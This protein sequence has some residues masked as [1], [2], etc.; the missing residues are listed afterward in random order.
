M[1]IPEQMEEM[2]YVPAEIMQILN[3]VYGVEIAESSA[4]IH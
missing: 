3:D 4:T 1:Y 2:D